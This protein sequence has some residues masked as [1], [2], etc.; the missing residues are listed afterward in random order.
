[1]NMQMQSSL[2]FSVIIIIGSCSIMDGMERKVETKDRPKLHIVRNSAL[3]RAVES[4]Q[5]GSALIYSMTHNE[6][7]TSDLKN[8][9]CQC[10]LEEQQAIIK[11]S[12]FYGDDSLFQAACESYATTLAADKVI[13]SLFADSERAQAALDMGDYVNSSVVKKLNELFPINAHFL[14]SQNSIHRLYNLSIDIKERQDEFIIP[15]TSSD[16]V[17]CLQR[18]FSL[19][20]DFCVKKGVLPLFVR[21]LRNKLCYLLDQEVISECMVKASP[22]NSAEAKTIYFDGRTYQLSADGSLMLGFTGRSKHDIDTIVMFKRSTGYIFEPLK[23]IYL[24]KGILAC[25]YPID[26]KQSLKGIPLCAMLYDIQTSFAIHPSQQKAAYIDTTHNMYILDL[27]TQ[28]SSQIATK[29]NALAVA[30]SQDGDSI[31]WSTSDGGVF[32]GMVANGGVKRLN[33]SLVLCR[34]VRK[35]QWSADGSKILLVSEISVDL[36][37]VNK[38]LLH[39]YDDS[40]NIMQAVL[41]DDATHMVV[42]STTGLISFVDLSTFAAEHTYALDDANVMGVQ[43]SPDSRYISIS[44]EQHGSVAL[45][46]WDIDHNTCIK[47]NGTDESSFF[48]VSA[49]LKSGWPSTKTISLPQMMLLVAAA[50]A[51]KDKTQFSVSRTHCLAAHLAAFAPHLKKV[52]EGKIVIKL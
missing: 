33:Y 41:S 3:S 10:S 23:A 17:V 7:N 37:D 15:T 36:L 12:E 11:A 42:V 5:Q 43:L 9:I 27:D 47:Y 25:R 20:S 24:D 48:M 45:Y 2:F 18:C 35:I 14:P 51:Q 29:G 31:A 21:S 19:T 46:V 38:G 6:A 1:M 32:V 30:W 13:T 28:E 16:D 50:K 8:K 52:L 40:Q 22:E 26:K 39:C 44:C 49:Q 4:H 34:P